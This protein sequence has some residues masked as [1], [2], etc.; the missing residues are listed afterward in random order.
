MIKIIGSGFPLSIPSSGLKVT[1]GDTPAQ[2]I[3][4]SSTQLS[5]KSP[6]ISTPG[7]KLIAISYNELQ[8][9][10]GDFNYDASLTPTIILLS[11]TEASPVQ[12]TDLE[13]EGTSFGGDKTKIRIFLENEFKNE[14]IY[15]LA[16]LSV[17]PTKIKC[18]LGGGQS[19]VYFVRV[20]VDG[21]GASIPATTDSNKFSYTIV[22]SSVEPVEGGTEGGTVVMIKGR[23][24]SPVK[25]ENQVYIGDDVNKYCDIMEASPTE[26]KCKTRKMTTASFIDVSIPVF[27]A[28]KVSAYAVCPF[29]FKFVTAKTPLIST[30]GELALKGGD[31]QILD[32]GI[33]LPEEGK[34]IKVE[35][36]S[37][38]SE[39]L[40]YETGVVGES[41]S[42]AQIKFI[43]P[44]MV[45]GTYKIKVLV[46]NI[47]YAV[48]PDE[49]IIVNS[50]GI[51]EF[52]VNDGKLA[53]TVGSRGG[54]LIKIKGNGFRTTDK[55]IVKDTNSYCN[56]VS[57]AVNEI[58]CITNELLDN[59]HYEVFI[60]RIDKTTIGCTNCVLDTSQNLLP[61]ITSVTTDI[62]TLGSNSALNL[63]GTNLKKSAVN[64]TPY[65][66]QID[67][68]NKVFVSKIAGSFVSSTDTTI[69]VSFNDIPSGNYSFS[70]YYEEYGFSYL[71]ETK[72][73]ALTI[74]L[75][76]LTL[77]VISSSIYGGKT[78][79]L[80]G[81][82]FPDMSKKNINNITICESICDIVSFT[83][84]NIDFTIPKLLTKT[85]VSTHSLESSESVLQ[86]DFKMTSDNLIKQNLVNDGLTST[87][88]D[89]TKAGCYIIFDFGESFQIK[90]KEIDFYMNLAKGINDYINLMFEFSNDLITF[91]PLYTLDNNIKTGWN[92]IPVTIDVA[93]YRYVRL[94]DP[95]GTK[96]RCNLAEIAFYGVK[97]YTK[98]NDKLLTDTLTCDVNIFINGYSYNLP[99]KIEYKASEMPKI[100][101]VSPVLGPSSGNT[102]VTITGEGFGTSSEAVEVKIDAVPCVIKTV[103]STQ[104]VCTT[105]ARTSFV[106]PSFT[107]KI[108]G[109][110]ALAKNLLFSYIDRWSDSN[111]WGGEDPPK[112]Y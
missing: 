71:K 76:D 13:V 67:T 6:T 48:V 8:T 34:S 20:E 72:L 17:E 66:N 79:S 32:G 98:Y 81:V 37:I 107:V 99:S 50:F 52:I 45:D 82:G 110:N 68:I 28:Q 30:T 29:F 94:N 36:Y 92:K 3:S 25:N 109:N 74:K 16:V 35:F 80:A 4:S 102:D 59:T 10:I 15:E 89:S 14:T 93:A 1:L 26:L 100:T 27:V 5:V 60:Y 21:V 91:I 42:E 77:G 90:F 111:T 58:V 83:S 40:A 7:D 11:R 75:T 23:N 46:E 84:S 73:K 53:S 38:V 19:G 41:I 57:Y 44:F 86:L 108:N 64:P 63:V 43:M 85:L 9:T 96:S 65:F 70:L 2:I 51:T 56:L 24:F 33:L 87:Y 104:I 105:G 18:L 55:V 69:S 54:F 78:V 61:I 62:L 22:V 95:T 101:G 97:L 39:S 49:L 31:A 88:Y 112:K 47:G 12:K 103:I 106:P